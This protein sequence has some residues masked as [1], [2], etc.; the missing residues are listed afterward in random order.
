MGQVVKI[1][2]DRSAGIECAAELVPQPGQYLLAHPGGSDSPL[3]V[4]LFFSRALADGFRTAPIPSDSW[5]PGMS[6]H[7]AGPL[8]HGFSIPS[9]A[10]KTVLVAFDDTPARLFGLMG[11]VLKQG[12]ELVLVTGQAAEDIPEA[13]EIQPLK[14]LDEILHWAD[15]A[16][17]DA[18]RE[19]LGQLLEVPAI[20]KGRVNETQVLLRAPMPCGTRAECGVCSL[21]VRG[22]WK[23]IC[24][25][26]PVFALKDLK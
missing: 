20:K 4:P 11:P 19:N 26:G 3:A 21:T 1:F 2:L 12:S 16:A 24:K 14:A 6:L 5:Q 8:G 25:D 9:F 10:R 17:V 23:M 7:L 18:A 22:E 15:F 13:I